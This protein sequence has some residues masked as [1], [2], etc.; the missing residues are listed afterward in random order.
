MSRL[1]SDVVAE[2]D[3]RV[4]GHDRAAALLGLLDLVVQV[5]QASDGGIVDPRD[6]LESERDELAV[7]RGLQI[8]PPG[9][10]S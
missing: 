6:V 8:E 7:E 1:S 10:W 4:E 5:A 3:S 2:S 9:C